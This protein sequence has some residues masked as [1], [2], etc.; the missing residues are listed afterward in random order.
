M[1]A[2]KA[3]ILGIGGA[4]LNIV[5]KLYKQGMK[6]A[7]FAA[8][9]TSK[10][11]IEILEK[12]LKSLYISY[13]KGVKLDPG[14]LF[15]PEIVKGTETVAG[16]VDEPKN[17]DIWTTT[18]A[19]GE[20][21][22]IEN[23]EAI[24]NILKGHDLLIIIASL[25]SG[26]GAGASLGIARMAIAYG[27]QVFAIVIMP[28]FIEKVRIEVANDAL[29]RLKPWCDAMLVIDN[30]KLLKN[31]PDLTFEAAFNKGTEMI[32]NAAKKLV[33]AHNALEVLL[34]DKSIENRKNDDIE[35]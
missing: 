8:I 29:P 21:A 34:L 22:V 30:N 2:K 35:K 18:P 1:Q 33:E 7:E 4:G 9:D 24:G 11:H 3:L 12:G 27:M 20:E 19:Y 10:S 17:I 16:Y 14:A 28:F 32:G 31:Y 15:S 6:G 23:Q 13:S 26:T 5:N 25:G